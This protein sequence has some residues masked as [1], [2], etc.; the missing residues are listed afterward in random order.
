M[1]FR[2]AVPALGARLGSYSSPFSSARNFAPILI[3]VGFKQ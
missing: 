2:V 3:L 1:N